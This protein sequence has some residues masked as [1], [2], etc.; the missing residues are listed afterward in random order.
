MGASET[1]FIQEL[2]LYAA[3]AALS[4]LVLFA[5]L[6]QLDP[7]RAASKKALEQK[8]EIAKRLGRPMIQT[9]QY[10]NLFVMERKLIE[11]PT[12]NP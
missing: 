5:G 1:R 12:E 4:C 3:S 9:N 10:E 7:N 2:V 11:F 6:R 8:K